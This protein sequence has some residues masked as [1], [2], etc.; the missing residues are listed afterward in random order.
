MYTKSFAFSG[1][2]KLVN[3]GVDI[4]FCFMNCFA[5]DLLASN[6]VASKVGPNM[7][8]L[9]DSSFTIPFV[10]GSSGPT[11][12]RQLFFIANDIILEKSIM[13]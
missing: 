5:K 1:S 11:T 12:T 7:L 8:I 13:E 9:S 2:E 3:S 10:N 6:L 4:L